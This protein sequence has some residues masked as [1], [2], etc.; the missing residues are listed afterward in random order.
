[1]D[2]AES[3]TSAAETRDQA[4]IVESQSDLLLLPYTTPTT[5]SKTPS[6]AAQTKDQICSS[7]RPCKKQNK[8]YCI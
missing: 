3:L 8:R 5:T 7:E 2:T 4:N 6:Q 1:M